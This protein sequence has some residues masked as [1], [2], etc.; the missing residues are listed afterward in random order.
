MHYR[1]VINNREG[2]ATKSCAKNVLLPHNSE[3]LKI[4]V[5]FMTSQ[6]DSHFLVSRV[7]RTFSEMQ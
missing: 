2:W 7:V 4:T 3:N 1:L 6:T 5:K